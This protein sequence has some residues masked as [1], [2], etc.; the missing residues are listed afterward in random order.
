MNQQQYISKKFKIVFSIIL[1]LAIVVVC[2][3]IPIGH[4]TRFHMHRIYQH[5]QIMQK[6]GLS[7]FSS[8]LFE[9]SYN[10][11]GYAEPLFYGSLF[12]APFSLFVV[13]GLSVVWAY[14]LL[15]LTITL[16]AFASAYYCVYAWQKNH[17]L[18]FIGGV[19]YI[20][21]PYFVIDVITRGAIGES[22][23]LIFLPI[24]MLSYWMILKQ[25]NVRKAI[26]LLAT[27]MSGIIYS[28]VNSTYIVVLSLLFLSVFNIKTIVSNLKIVID[29]AISAL[30]CLV[31]SAG[32]VFP[33]LEQLTYQ[34]YYFKVLNGSQYYDKF[35]GFGLG[36]LFVPADIFYY[37]KKFILH[38]TEL[39]FGGFAGML[40]F[41]TILALIKCDIKKMIA[42][43]IVSWSIT[44]LCSE[45]HLAS[46]LKPV[47]GVIQFPWR[48]F[49]LVVVTTVILII[50]V[51]VNIA[52]KS[53]TQKMLMFNL[54]FILLMQPMSVIVRIAMDI[55]PDKFYEITGS[56]A[57]GYEYDD[58]ETCG[59]DDI[60]VPLEVDLDDIDSERQV[61]C[62]RGT[63]DYTYNLGDG[64]VEVNYTASEACQFEIPFFMYLG[65]TA[66]AD[67]DGSE[68]TLTVSK[69]EN[70]LVL[71]DAPASNN[72]NILVSYSGT[73]LMFISKLLSK[74]ALLVLLIY[75]LKNNNIWSSDL[76]RF[77]K[78]EYR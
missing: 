40:L 20:L 71:V 46:F 10:G 42:P 36:N 59:R 3:F 32:F 25:D 66:V 30:I 18:A 67:I 1:L 13:A 11:Y 39:T 16:C 77:V 73:Q 23:G 12:L 7:A 29:Y 45:R 58:E 52:D 28:H 38:R 70:G 57:V 53:I 69:S 5:A 61:I 21:S 64:Y 35:E 76:V 51:V 31:L 4:D 47:L 19:T 9:T 65:Y 33:L 14:K 44:I 60:Y 48:L 26:L 50:L 43:L 34:A 63:A 27:S 6:Y 78:N 55:F 8:K 41:V 22:L 56:E 17:D 74:V 62:T 68:T 15:V 54:I 72:A 49:I 37:I 2:V 75:F 24:V